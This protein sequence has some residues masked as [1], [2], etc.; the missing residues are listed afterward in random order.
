MITRN[1]V[2]EKINKYL[3]HTISKA[4][5]I[6]WAESALNDEDFE[7]KYFDQINEALKKIGLADVNNFDLV[8]E[9]YENILK[10]LDYK[11][12]VEISRV[13]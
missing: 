3:N 2:V 8:W 7:E 4:Q 6:G 9:D 10:S 5:L 11:I 12:T 1:Q 13:S